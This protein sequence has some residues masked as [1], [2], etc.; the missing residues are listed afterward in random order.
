MSELIQ[1]EIISDGVR[2]PKQTIRSTRVARSDAV[3]TASNIVWFIAGVLLVLLAFRFVLALLGANSANNFTHFIY[4][5]TYP[6]ASP[7]FG[8]FGYTIHYGVSEFELS[9]L[10]AM[11]VYALIAFGI[12]KLI[13]IRRV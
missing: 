6:F 5:I 1:K 3:N 2:A 4:T 9:T 7:F 12:T 11:V 8:V 10:V 13:T